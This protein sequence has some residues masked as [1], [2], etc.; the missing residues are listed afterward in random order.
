MHFLAAG[1]DADVYALD[2]HRVLRRYRSGGDVSAEAAV[3]AHVRAHGFPVPE[4]F[5]A[6]GTDIVMERLR[7][8]TMLGSIGADPAEAAVVLAT[9]HRRL[10][11]VPGRLVPDERV[12]HLDL[13]P[14][15]VVLTANGPVVIDWRNA[16]EGSP[17]L[18]VAMSALILGQVAVGG[19]ELAAPASE[20][21]APF[22]A[23]AG[24]I[25][26]QLRI[27]VGMRGRDRNISEQERAD[28]SRAADLVRA[29]TPA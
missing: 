18:D 25:G 9:L 10:H 6:A 1:R 26:S 7:G 21:L 11:A 3:M 22:L 16:R 8:A 4:V 13:H 14:D 24:P 12:L 23:D 15:N 27:A 17:E 19:S 5:D 28:L 2:E 29:N 20:M